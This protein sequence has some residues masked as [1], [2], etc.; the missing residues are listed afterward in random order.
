MSG[1]V[2]E[3]R[4]AHAARYDRL[5]GDL[6]DVVPPAVAEGATHVYQMYTVQLPAHRRDAALRA[7]RARGIGASVHFDPP[8]H[9]QPAYLARGCREGQ[10]PETE[11]LV[12][13]IVTLPMY[14][15]MTEADQDWVVESLRAAVAA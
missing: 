13:G 1:A 4:I 7:M 12:R 2:I 6:P 14:P 3:R 11:R 8:V 10:L 5:I 15:D 9:L